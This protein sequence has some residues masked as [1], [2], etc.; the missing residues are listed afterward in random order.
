MRQ[1]PRRQRRGFLLLGTPSV[2]GS[3]RELNMKDPMDIDWST[4]PA[5][6]DDGGAR[7]LTGQRLPGVALNST[8]GDT[9][10]LSR[11]VGR[12]V[13]YAYPR[14]KPADEPP[15]DGWLMIPG[16]PGCT[17]Q[18]CAFRDHA[19]QIKAAGASHIFG[20]S[21][22]DTPYQRGA[23]ERL[24][25]PYPLLSDDRLLFTNA[26]SLPTFASAGM[27]LLKRLTMVINDGVIERVFYPVFPPDR[28]AAEVLA[29]LETRCD[30]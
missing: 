21:T 7:H 30:Q 23:V 9:V 24:R 1:K 2:V 26:L 20:L 15:P 27:T 8:D 11:L 22:Q 17:P 28:N 3:L 13:I 18:S 14:K 12:A 5:P 16:A 19:M 29:W 4:M 6:I 25:L 10:D